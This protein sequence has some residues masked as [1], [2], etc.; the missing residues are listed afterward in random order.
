MLD[1]RLG[2]GGLLIMSSVRL[3]LSGVCLV[4][5]AEMGGGNWEIG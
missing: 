5:L 3:G 1:F 4:G 2:R